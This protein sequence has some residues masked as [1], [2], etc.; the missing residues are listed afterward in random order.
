MVDVTT[1]AALGGDDDVEFF[2]DP[3]LLPLILN[4]L[5]KYSNLSVYAVDATG[6]TLHD[7]NGSGNSYS[8]GNSHVNSHTASPSLSLEEVNLNSNQ[9]SKIISNHSKNGSNS[10]TK[11][12]SSGGGGVTA[13]T[14]GVFPDKEVRQYQVNG[15]SGSY[16]EC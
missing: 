16:C 5:N 3:D 1:K 11:K 6:I 13:V 9:K 7:K 8:D 2:V 10:L 4:I 14:W 15:I 12:R